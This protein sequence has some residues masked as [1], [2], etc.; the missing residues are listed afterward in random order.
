[1]T[2]ADIFFTVAVEKLRKRNELR[3]KNSANPTGKQKYVAKCAR[4]HL[5]TLCYWQKS[6]DTASVFGFHLNFGNGTPQ[7]QM[8]QIKNVILLNF[9]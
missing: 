7:K 9:L 2:F 3:N 1:M 8:F 5:D 4:A 6:L